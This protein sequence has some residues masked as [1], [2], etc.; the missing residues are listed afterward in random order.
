MPAMPATRDRAAVR[1]LFLSHTYVVGANQ[2]KLDALASLPSMVVGALVPRSWRADQWRRRYR[3]EQ[4]TARA[5]LF[6]TRV[7]FEGRSGAYLFPVRALARV[8]RAFKPDVIQVE[9]EAFGM[10]AIQATALAWL[11]RRPLVLF[12][13]ENIDHRLSMPRRAGR[14]LVL[15]RATCV[16]AGSE[17]AA[18]TVRRWGFRGRVEVMP[19]L[20]IDLTAAPRRRLASP[21]PFVVGYAGRLAPEKGVDV[22]TDAVAALAGDGIDVR[23][24]IV[25][26]GPHEQR[27]RQHAAEAGIDG[28][29]TWRGGLPHDGVADAMRRMDVLVLPSRSSPR[30]CEQFGHVLIEAMALSV[31]VVGSRSG[32]IPEVVGRDD[33]LFDEEDVSALAAI[34]HRLASEPAWR[35]S[36]G[37]WGR[38]RVVEHFTNDRIAA[39]L[40]ALYEDVVGAA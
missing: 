36:V 15:R 1:V 37:T 39:K 19:Q 13:W 40:A 35:E 27:L 18:A 10:V 29:V 17:G 2:R 33:L 25:G 26:T 34:L 3:F 38:D 12:C 9:A 16:V 30:W 21:R 6:A 31:P 20:G 32:A 5:R 23:L 14:W 22:L 7:W 4:A 11:T 24:E 28:L 8:V